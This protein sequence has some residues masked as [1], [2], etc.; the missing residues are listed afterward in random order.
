M[1]SKKS[2]RMLPIQSL[3]G[4][5]MHIKGDMKFKGGLRIDGE[6]DGNVVAEEGE[7]SLLVIS[8]TGRVRG[9]VQVGHVVVSGHIVGPIEAK[10]L[11]E[12]HPSANVSGDVRYKALEMHPGAVVDGTLQ[13]EQDDSAPAKLALAS[14]KAGS[15]SKQA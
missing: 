4:A 15:G 10:E 11:L 6:V 13:H 2:K 12:L 14:S 8:E 1:F 7:K 5:G 3:V 9:S